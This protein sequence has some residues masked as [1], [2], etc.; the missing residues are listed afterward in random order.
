MSIPEKE[1]AKLARTCR[2]LRRLPLKCAV[3]VDIKAECFKV[4]KSVISAPCLEGF[5]A[6]SC[7]KYEPTPREDVER[8][9]GPVFAAADALI[10]R[11]AEGKC[12]HCG[13]EIQERVQQGHCVYAQP[14]G[15][16]LGTA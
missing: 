9:W 14:C 8:Q 3:G 6:W 2:N 4:G 12:G 13:A 16:R 11:M 7:D 5:G 10:D 1:M 15:H